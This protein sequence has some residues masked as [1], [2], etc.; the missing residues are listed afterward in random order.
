[1]RDVLTASIL[2]GHLAV[3]AAASAQTPFDHLK[4]RRVCDTIAAVTARRAWSVPRGS[5]THPA[6]PLSRI[7]LCSAAMGI[8]VTE[9]GVLDEEARLFTRYLV[10][11]MPPPDLIARYA[12]ADRT[13][14]TTP[15][16]PHEAGLVQFVRRHP[17][18]VGLLD[19]AAGLLQP[20]GRLHG[21][22]LVMSAI[23]ETSPVFAD[24]FLPRT[25]RTPSLLLRLV[26]AGT[27]ALAQALLGA[28]LY[29]FAI[30]TR[31]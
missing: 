14:W 2:V 1:M 13:I 20:S 31:A 16:P 18:S 23:L 12:E 3:A 26:A 19:A 28:L 27:A 24:E 21:K 10:G 15:A 17:W 4:C 7:V 8:P 22:I 30:R 9:H 6:L 25:V 11:R 29:P 5:G